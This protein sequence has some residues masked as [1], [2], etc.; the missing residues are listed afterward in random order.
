M[1]D[2][3]YPASEK[4]MTC[5]REQMSLISH[6]HVCFLVKSFQIFCFAAHQDI[7]K[8]VLP[9]SESGSITAMCWKLMGR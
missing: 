1:K 4:N 7:L 6:K 2:S 5:K 8:L 3:R 9:M